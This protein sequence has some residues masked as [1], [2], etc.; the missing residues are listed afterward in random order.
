[1]TMVGGFSAAGLKQEISDGGVV[2][3]VERRDGN[4]GLE[5]YKAAEITCDVNLGSQSKRKE[6]SHGW[7]CRTD[8][9]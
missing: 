6:R 3:G 9:I 4:L 1:M 8:V 5:V 7:N 2:T